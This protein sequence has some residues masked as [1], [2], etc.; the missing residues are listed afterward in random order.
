MKIKEHLHFIY[1]ITSLPANLH[2]ILK[3]STAF[4]KQL[5]HHDQQLGWKKLVEEFL[6]TEELI[7][8]KGI[9]TKLPWVENA[10]STILIIGRN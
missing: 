9:G 6:F 8:L 7:K 1:L 2:L 10:K 5:S 4:L 3:D